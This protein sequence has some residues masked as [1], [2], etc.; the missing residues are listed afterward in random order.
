MAETIIYL[1]V[2][3]PAGIALG[4]IFARGRFAAQHGVMQE[5]LAGRER[6]LQG[7]TETLRVRE[8]ELKR[9]SA[10]AS[11]LRRSARLGIAAKGRSGRRW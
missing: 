11:E 1:A 9:E 6:E 4:W 3:V 2:G 10:S 5:R 7:A 8:E